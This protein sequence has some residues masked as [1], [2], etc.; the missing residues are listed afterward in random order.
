MLFINL[1]STYSCCAN[2]HKIKD[3]TLATLLTRWSADFH[4]TPTKVLQGDCPI[5]YDFIELS[6]YFGSRSFSSSTEDEDDKAEAAKVTRDN[7]KQSPELQKLLSDLYEDV[8]NDDKNVDVITP[9][10]QNRKM[11]PI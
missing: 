11:N 3:F 7:L 5:K 9:K 10:P 8:E 4:L 1:Q 6:G 2:I